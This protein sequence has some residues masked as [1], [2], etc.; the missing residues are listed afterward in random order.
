M[1]TYNFKRLLNLIGITLFKK[2]CI[3]IKNNNLNQIREEIA[4]HILTFGVHL[5]QKLELFLFLQ[6]ISKKVRYL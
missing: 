5:V 4:A 3:A 6:N 2:L 1:F